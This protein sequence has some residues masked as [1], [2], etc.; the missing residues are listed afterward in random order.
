MSSS[1]TTT[2]AEINAFIYA[3]DVF[4][5]FWSYLL[6]CL[7][8]TGHA[9]N[10]YVFTRSILR[11]NPCTRYFLAATISGIFCTYINVLLRLIQNLYP[12][13]N[14]FGYSTASCKILS[15]IVYCSRC[16]TSWF[17]VLA[18]IDRYLCSS[19]S[20]IVRGLSSIRMTS[21][22]ILFVILAVALCYLYVPIRFENIQTNVKC[23]GTQTTYPLFNGI[24][25]LLIFSLGPPIM[26]LIFGSITIHHI[27]Q[28]VRRSGE[29]NIRPQTLY[30][31]IALVPDRSTRQKA[32]DQQLIR[33]MLVQCLYFSLLS[34]PVSMLYMY[35][36]VRN[37]AEF[38]ALQAARENLFINI[39]GLLSITGACTSFYIFTLSSP[40]FRRELLYL[41]KYQRQQNHNMSTK[42]RTRSE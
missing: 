26:M 10:I 8:T 13:Y 29:K 16:V 37:S 30:E 15:Y 7:G 41:L 36:A 2:R 11:S 22:A 3:N 39:C 31:S 24:W 34:T 21:R 25:N 38:D 14:P 23:P 1:N 18:S 4:S 42:H 9:L 6:I 12:D 5:R 17:I 35:L 32:I 40:L 27:Q 20:A 19:S 28:S 33:M